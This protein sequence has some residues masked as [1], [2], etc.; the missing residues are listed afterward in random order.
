MGYFIA[1][2]LLILV[3]LVLC[4]LVDTAVPTPRNPFFLGVRTVQ[5]AMFLSPLLLW[6]ASCKAG[7]LICF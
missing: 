4:S 2:V 1:F 5:I 6:L 7:G 3:L